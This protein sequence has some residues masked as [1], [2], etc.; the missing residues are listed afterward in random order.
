MSE[1]R[2]LPFG[3]LSG[4]EVSTHQFC[5]SVSQETIDY[6]DLVTP[7]A[8]APVL[9]KAEEMKAFDI[10]GNRDNEIYFPDFEDKFRAVFTETLL[11][12][13][14]GG[15]QITGDHILRAYEQ[16]VETTCTPQLRSLM[17]YPDSYDEM[18]EHFRVPYAERTIGEVATANPQA[19]R[20]YMEQAQ[21]WRAAI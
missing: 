5:R 19:A 4:P 6:R 17:Y 21:R 20:A 3:T 7:T 12:I 13:A 2:P 11:I 8:L 14:N 16:A 1:P 10:L 18:F 9:K 15:D